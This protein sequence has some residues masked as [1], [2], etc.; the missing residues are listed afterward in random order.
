VFELLGRRRPR[1]LDG[2]VEDADDPILEG[3]L[4]AHPVTRGLLKP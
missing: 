2:R 4:D 3:H 1:I